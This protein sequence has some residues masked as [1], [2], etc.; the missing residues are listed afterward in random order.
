MRIFAWGLNC[1][2]LK[3]SLRVENG[4]FDAKIGFKVEN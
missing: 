2:A 4:F 3:F 1:E